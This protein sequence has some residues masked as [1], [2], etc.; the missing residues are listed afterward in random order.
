M[1]VLAAAAPVFSAM[2]LAAGPAPLGL[3]VVAAALAAAVLHAIWN[4]IAAGISD[5]LVGFA[6]IGAA[7]TG[8]CAVGVAITG[9]PPAAAWVFIIAS[10][11]VHVVYQLLLLASYQLGEFS[12]VYPLARGTSPWV[13][14]LIS[15]TVLGHDLPGLEL[16]GVLVVSAGLISLVFLGGRPTKAQL[17]ALAAAFGTGLMIAT[18]TVIDGL[19]VAQAPV[20]TY[21]AWMFL[22]QGPALPLLAVWRRGRALPRQLHGVV[23]V[24]LAG[25]VISLAAYG[26]ILWAQTSG[27]LAPIAALR[28]SSIIFGALIGALFFGERLGRGRAIAATVV[29]AGIALIS[30]P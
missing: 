1:V 13:V 14:A 9:P 7:Y 10:A 28:E 15:V 19:G 26:L 18:Y 4:A 5:R 21:A 23:G 17:P 30:L 2:P 20:A 27:A 16:A 12:Q 25:G 8:V 6:L 11:A 22:L 3:G 24:G 29:V